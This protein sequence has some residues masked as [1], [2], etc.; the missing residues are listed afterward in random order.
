MT[1]EEIFK[2]VDKAL[3]NKEKKYNSILTGTLLLI[4]FGMIL[5]YIPADSSGI[6]WVSVIVCLF[7]FISFILYF[8]IIGKYTKRYVEMR[9]NYMFN[10]VRKDERK[11]I[12]G[13]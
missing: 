4:A 3:K 5:M 7:W 2:Y 9:R 8:Y 13:K 11:R 6:T 12:E 1:N 10:L